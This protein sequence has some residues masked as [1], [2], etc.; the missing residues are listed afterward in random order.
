MTKRTFTPLAELVTP[1]QL[2]NLKRL[3]AGLTDEYIDENSEVFDMSSFS[4]AAAPYLP[5]ASECGT[6][7]CLAGHGPKFGI[8]A[9]AG[10]YW[11]P[12]VS[13]VFGASPVLTLSATGGLLMAEDSQRAV[14]KWLFDSNWEL[15]DNSL[16]GARTRLDIA[17]ELGV[18]S[19]AGEQSSILSDAE[20]MYD[21][22]RGRVLEEPQP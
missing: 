12:Y 4:A 14:W 1:E 17:L 9:K 10:E 2:E 13:R 18:P 20:L 8:S 6:V 5:Q 3:R 15:T 16:L 7:A 19:D 11:Q 21:P 22:A